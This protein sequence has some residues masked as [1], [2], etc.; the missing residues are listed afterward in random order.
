M[1]TGVI[2]TSPGVKR[3]FTVVKKKSPANKD[4]GCHYVREGVSGFNT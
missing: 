2:L 4:R 3:L 1:V